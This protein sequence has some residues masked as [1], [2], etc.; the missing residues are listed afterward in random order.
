MFDPDRVYH[1]PLTE[2]F[3]DDTFN[4][5]GPIAP[6]TVHDLSRSIGAHGLHFPIIVRL[7]EDAGIETHKY[8]LVAGHRRYKA[9]ELF[10][11]WKMIPTLIRPGLDDDAARELNLIENIDREDLPVVDQAKAIQTTFGDLPVREIARRLN[12]G[13]HWVKYRLGL[14]ELS[15]R[16]QKYV[17]RG[18]L[19]L[20]DIE[21][22]L[23][24]SPEQRDKEAEILVQKKMRGEPA[25]V[26]IRRSRL[27][28]ASEIKQM[29]ASLL[30][31]GAEGLGTYALAWAV[32][33][34]ETATFEEHVKQALRDEGVKDEE[35]I[36]ET[37][38]LDSG[39]DADLVDT[40]V[41]GSSR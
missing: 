26:R 33:E 29:T 15:P 41:P 6:Q 16:L 27:R 22:L 32:G 1:L 24:V 28:K 7:A 8:H 3:Y 17:A 13:F 37:S 10:L 30:H 18:D 23:R 38:N 4:C 31:R 11:K 21:L 35:L 36:I 9:V 25:S 20:R 19:S 12:R 5:R 39:L 40:M 34:M 2:I 14:L